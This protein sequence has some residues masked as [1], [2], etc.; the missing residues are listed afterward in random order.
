MVMPFPSTTTFKRTACTLAT[1]TNQHSRVEGCPKSAPPAVRLVRL[2]TAPRVTQQRARLRL[3]PGRA[4]CKGPLLGT[5]GTAWHYYCTTARHPARTLILI[6]MTL[7]EARSRGDAVGGGEHA[8]RAEREERVDHLGARGQRSKY[9]CY[10]QDCLIKSVAV[11]VS[12]SSLPSV[13]P[14]IMGVVLRLQRMTD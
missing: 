1:T 13:R 11:D 4:A 8:A 9:N 5:T 14:T 6:N 3:A 10:S 2:F 12:S 7:R